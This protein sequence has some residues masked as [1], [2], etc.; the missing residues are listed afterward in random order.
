[1]SRFMD[2][3]GIEGI[4]DRSVGIDRGTNADYGLGMIFSG[5]A[6]GVIDGC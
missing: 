4:I 6:L 5:I 1:M 3:L 2:R